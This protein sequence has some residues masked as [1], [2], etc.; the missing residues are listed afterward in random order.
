MTARA[1][2][3]ILFSILM[4]LSGCAV[5][6]AT[7][8]T[9][10]T[11][12]MSREDEI[13]IGAEEHPKLINEFGGAYSDARL[14]AYVRRIGLKLARHADASGLPYTFTILNSDKV[15]ALALPGGYVYITRGL[16]ALAENEAE[17]AGV[18]A[19]EIGHVTA[20]HTAERYS[21]AQATNIGLMVLD[22]LG[23]AAGVPGGVGQLVGRSDTSKSSFRSSA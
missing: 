17:M 9:S 8:K 15:N 14:Q 3:L 22:A 6:P 1:P 5:N 7:G 16:L 19:H 18:L 12:F 4:A 23:S 2:I 21:T 11:A 20:R 10:F 13:R